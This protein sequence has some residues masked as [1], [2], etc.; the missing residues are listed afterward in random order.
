MCVWLKLQLEIGCTSLSGPETDFFSPPKSI[1][2]WKVCLCWSPATTRTSAGITQKWH[3][4]F[5]LFRL[6]N[7]FMLLSSFP[8]ITPERSGL[9]S[10]VRMQISPANYMFAI[11]KYLEINYIPSIHPMP[12][13]LMLHPSLT[14]KQDPDKNIPP[15]N[16][17]LNII[18]LSFAGSR[19]RSRS[20]TWP[21]RK[22]LQKWVTSP[23]SW[24]QFM[25]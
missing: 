13:S 21:S 9:V 11:L 14:R 1:F 20:S 7:Y 6:M 15:T 8:V 10:A 12:G 25:S 5:E 24:V 17:Y 16:M 3:H 19:S 4:A 22:L 23:D 18:F 2:L